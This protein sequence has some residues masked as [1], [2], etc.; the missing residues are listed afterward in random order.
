MVACF[1]VPIVVAACLGY[2]DSRASAMQIAAC[3]RYRASEDAK[4]FFR[5]FD[6][7]KYVLPCGDAG[8]MLGAHLCYI[9]GRVLR[10]H[11]QSCTG[12][13]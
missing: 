8:H 5:W 10:L 3:F 9:N 13:E 7:K 1:A 6:L 4:D 11:R 2:A 12:N